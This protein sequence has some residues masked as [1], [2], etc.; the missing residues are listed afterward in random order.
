MAAAH[1][2]SDRIA[3]FARQLAE[4]ELGEVDDS[5]ALS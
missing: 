1:G 4:E 5:N 2:V 3:A